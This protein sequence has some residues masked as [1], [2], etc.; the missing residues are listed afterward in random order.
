MIQILDIDSLRDFDIPKKYKTIK[1]ETRRYALP[2]AAISGL[3]DLPAEED[4]GKEECYGPNAC[5]M[6]A[7]RQQV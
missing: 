3:P 6:L 2:R 1:A 5:T 4:Q 7:Y